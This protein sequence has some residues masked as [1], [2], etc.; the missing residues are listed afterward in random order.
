LALQLA[1]VSSTARP[2][3]NTSPS[4]ANSSGLF[5][6]TMGR[7]LWTR[8]A[9]DLVRLW[10]IATAA[11]SATTAS[12]RTIR[13]LVVMTTTSLGHTNDPASRGTPPED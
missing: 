4:K 1:L 9:D 10:A 6:V 12:A 7:I 3:E 2:G 13:P 5:K 8:V 11:M